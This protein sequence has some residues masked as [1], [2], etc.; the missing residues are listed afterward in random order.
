MDVWEKA[1]TLCARY[2]LAKLS[3]HRIHRSFAPPISFNHL[4]AA[5]Q[6]QFL[7]SVSSE[8][9]KMIEDKY[10]SSH[11]TFWNRIERKF[12]IAQIQMKND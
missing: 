9:V 6:P 2:F 5:T 7:S 10:N 1:H 4:A 12:Y 8:S 11:A 3:F